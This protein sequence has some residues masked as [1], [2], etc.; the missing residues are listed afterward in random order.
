MNPLPPLPAQRD[1]AAALLAPAMPP[2][3]G[4][5]THNGSDVRTRFNVYRNNVLVTLVAALADTFP[6]LHDL[7]GA[8][9]FAAMARE[10][11]TAHPPCSP[12]LAHYGEGFADWVAG[13]EPAAS[14]PY[15]SDMARLERA[16]VRAFHAADVRA[17]VAGD[18]AQHLAEPQRLPQARLQLHPSLGVIDSPWAIVSLW[19]AHRGRGALDDVDP[20]RPEAALVLRFGDDVVVLGIDAGTARFVAGLQ[21]GEPLGRVGTVDAGLDLSASLALLIRYG[22]ICAWHD[23]GENA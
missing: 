17:L 8:E 21:R 19:A 13:F 15:L 12:V 6:V 7:V 11:V 9:F 23:D 10:Y 4:L 1:F 16:R 3:P 5:R 22:A 18:L 14:R 2:P 20:A